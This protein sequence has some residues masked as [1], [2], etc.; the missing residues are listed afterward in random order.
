MTRNDLF[1]RLARFLQSFTAI[2]LPI[3]YLFSLF[4]NKKKKVKI[5]VLLAPPRSGS[6]LTYQVL[7]TGIESLYLSNMSNF[8]YATPII[9]NSITKF[10][11]A[12]KTSKFKSKY[13]LVSGI[14]GEAEGLKYWKYWMNQGL[15]E[16]EKTTVDLEKMKKLRK[17]LIKS[18]L[19]QKPLIWG[20]LG[21]V[22]CFEQLS[23]FFKN[24]IVFLHLQRD[25]LSNAYS[26]L[27]ASPEELISSRPLKVQFNSGKDHQSIHQSIIEQVSAIHH[28]IDQ[29]KTETSKIISIRYKDLC[30][31]PHQFLDNLKIELEKEGF[32][33]NLR[34]ERIPKKFSYRT[35]KS[36]H[37][38]DALALSK[39]IRE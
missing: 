1:I 14:F 12:S 24:E 18:S 16:K 25:L 34:K 15:F 27:K 7:T 36:N 5:L 37:D 35:I 4:L 3:E 6:T 38:S 19:G 22:F 11:V 8:L 17:G 2:F 9:G 30:E 10:K 32:I 23:S 20:Y 33:I 26:L 31:N 28:R 13:G 29:K 21:H 39:F